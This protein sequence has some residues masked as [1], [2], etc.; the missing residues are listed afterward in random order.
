MI[1]ERLDSARPRVRAGLE[2]V[3][4]D[5]EIVVY[6]AAHE[7]LHRLNATAAAVWRACD[8]ATRVDE[9]AREVSEEYAGAD[10]RIQHDVRTVVRELLGAALLE[11]PSDATRR[12]R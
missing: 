12:S 8:G 5:G 1:L 6:D 7:Q 2:W 3:E 10:D 4:L 11:L 9:V